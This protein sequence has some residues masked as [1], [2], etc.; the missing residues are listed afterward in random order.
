MGCRSVV[1]AAAGVAGVAMGGCF[2]AR[3]TVDV[4]STR[5]DGLSAAGQRIVVV[6]EGRHTNEEEFPL[7]RARYRVERAS[8]GAVLFEGERLAEAVLP[9]AGVQRFEL[10]AAIPAEAGLMSGE[11]LVVSGT[12]TYEVPGTIAELLFDTRVRR[13]KARF[14]AEVVAP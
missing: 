4:V 6:L 2:H 7:E 3:P 8:D 9:P 14:V 1:V 13:P 10:P 5:A 12:V 11:P